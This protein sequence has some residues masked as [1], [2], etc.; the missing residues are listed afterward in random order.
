MLKKITAVMVRLNSKWSSQIFE[1]NNLLLTFIGSSC[2]SQGSLSRPYLAEDADLA[3]S[4]SALMM[5][6][7]GQYDRKIF[8]N[9]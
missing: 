3:Y 7:Q 9:R 2:F 6:L 1:N 5:H 8:G 4:Y